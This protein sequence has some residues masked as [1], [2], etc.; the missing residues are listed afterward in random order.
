[1]KNKLILSVSVVLL[2]FGLIVSGCNLRGVEVEEKKARLARESLV[3]NLDSR[4]IMNPA[5][6]SIYDAIGDPLVRFD[7]TLM[8]FVPAIASDW[9][10]E[11]NNTVFTFEIRDDVYFHNNRQV[12]AEDIKFTFE[13]LFDSENLSHS[14]DLL[15]LIEGTQEKMKCGEDDEVCGIE[16]IDDNKIQF[17][18]EEPCADFL[19]I[20]AM[21]TYA[22][23]N[24]EEVLEKE[25]SYGEIGSPITST[26]GPYQIK[27]YDYLDDGRVYVAL[28]RSQ[29]YFG[30]RPY[31]DKVIYEETSEAWAERFLDGYYDNVTMTY[32][33]ERLEEYEETALSGG[34]AYFLFNTQKELWQDKNIRKAI[35]YALDNK[36]LADF[37]EIKPAKGFLPINMPG[38]EAIEEKQY[39]LELAKKYLERAGY[40]NGKGLPELEL[41]I[42]PQYEFEVEFM[43]FV[44]EELEK[45]GIKS[46]V[47][48]SSM[49]EKEIYEVPKTVDIMNF[50]WT[51]DF[52]STNAMFGLT[53]DEDSPF[54]YFNLKHEKVHDILVRAEEKD[55][56]HDRYDIYN[57]ANKAIN[58]EVLM[59]PYGY[60]VFKFYASERLANIR[61][62]VGGQLLIREL[63]LR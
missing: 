48:T 29:N 28:E 59:V 11:E 26:T 18:L 36:K 62:D 44:Q 9:T 37:H 20:I 16:I 23:I 57:K 13:R 4:D 49:D 53:L 10:A 12:T 15:M 25:D 60:Y 54:N 5:I 7:Y 38:V 24:K 55:D 34:T 32:S 45:I 27:E 35:Y 3:E 19:N 2:L 41:H 56:V 8:Q 46:I 6:Y 61:H 21:P 43:H 1:M 22:I 14:A 58:D 33:E 39:D 31:L 17:T 63:R 50:G 51:S 40:P 47:T 42:K 30:D 52:M